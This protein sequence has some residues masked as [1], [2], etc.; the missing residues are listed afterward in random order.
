LQ[1]ALARLGLCGKERRFCG[2]P[3]AAEFD[4]RPPDRSCIIASLTSALLRPEQ[5]PDAA[6]LF[7]SSSGRLGRLAFLAGEGTVLG[8]LALYDRHAHGAA[9][10]LS[11]WLV[12]FALLFSGCCLA[13]R[14]LHDL[15]RSGWWTG[16]ILLLFLFAWPEPAGVAGWTA[17]GVLATL[18]LWLALTPGQPRPNRFGPPLGSPSVRAAG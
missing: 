7:F 12:L 6:E 8:L 14:R 5:R 11:G 4:R 17:R 18:A 2:A 1:D 13:A 15:G 16:L 10:L 9:R 3:S